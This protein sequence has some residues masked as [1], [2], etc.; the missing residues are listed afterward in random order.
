MVNIS[1]Y[2]IIHEDIKNCIEDYVE[3]LRNTISQYDKYP[4]ERFLKNAEMRRIYDIYTK[5]PFYTK[6]SD[7]YPYKSLNEEVHFRKSKT[8]YLMKFQSLLSP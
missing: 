6:K 2:N 5:D 7:K 1:A 4:L 8:F 3:T